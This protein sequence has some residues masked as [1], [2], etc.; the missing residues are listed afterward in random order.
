MYARIVAAIVIALAF[1][2]TYWKGHTSGAKAVQTLWDADVA[3]RTAQA[4]TESETRRL[5]E[6]AMAKDFSKVDHELQAAKTRRSVDSKFVADQLQQ[7][8]AINDHLAATDPARDAGGID[9]AD[10]RTAIIGECAAALATLDKAYGE[11]VD[12]ARA[13]QA[14]SSVVRVK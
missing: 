5:R 8:K 9:G 14:L 4:L 6:R 12:K 3:Q 11:L 2:G 13:M 7:L 1:A 10:P